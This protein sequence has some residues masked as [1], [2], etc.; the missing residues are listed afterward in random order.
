MFTG[1]CTHTER[2]VAIKAVAVAPGLQA[3]SFGHEAK[4]NRA[5]GRHSNVVELLGSFS[6]TKDTGFLVFELC[7]H[8]EAFEQIEPGKGLMPR[9]L[10]GCAPSPRACGCI[11]P[12]PE[13]TARTLRS[14]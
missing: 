6:P 1:R 12:I 7:A 8:G 3:D 2:D 4:V 14:W 11:H 5:L 9:S 10:L 13:R